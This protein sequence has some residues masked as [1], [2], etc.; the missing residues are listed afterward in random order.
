[1]HLVSVESKIKGT[2]QNT[3]SR[4]V[5]TRAWIIREVD[6]A[7]NIT[8]DNVVEHVEM[9]NSVEGREEVH[10]DSATDPSPPP[11]FENVAVSIGKVLASI[12]IDPQGRILS[13]TNN[14]AQYNPGIGDLTVP[15]PPADKQPI[16][17]GITWS[18]ADELRLPLD[19]GSIKKVQTQQQYK[20]EK[21][22]NGVATISVVTMV[23]TPIN[24]PKLKSQLVQRLQ[25]GS[26]KFDIDAGRL[27]HKQFDI[28]E[29]VVGFSGADS[30]MQYLGR[31][32]EEPV[33]EE[34]RSARR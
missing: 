12:K 2:A 34:A 28:G 8:F 14:Q 4:S 26:I 5:S 22:E 9:W 27:I 11:G 21:V 3:K 7:G 19:D 25:K 20:L 10:Y 17:P 18:I 24:D 23:L 6:S 1:V 32:T 15:F 30:Y 16:K 33:K 13:R 29:E 31:L